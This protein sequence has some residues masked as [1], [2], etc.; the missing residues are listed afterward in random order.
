MTIWR[1]HTTRL[2]VAT[3]VYVV[4]VCLSNRSS[5]KNVGRR[6][7]TASWSDPK[8]TVGKFD[9]GSANKQLIE[10]LR[11]VAFG[12]SKTW[13]AGLKDPEHEVSLQI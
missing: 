13:G 1:R 2:I 6:R 12:T 10:S 8:T 11:I 3:F 7:L 9:S 5:G 4:V